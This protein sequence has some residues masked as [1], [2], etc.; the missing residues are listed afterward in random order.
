[1][2]EAE[3]ILN[4]DDDEAGRYAK[5]R[6][7]ERAGLRVAEAATGE[8][9]LRHVAE[10]A[11]D[12][13]LLDVRLPDISGIEVCR[14]I[15][16]E[17]PGTLVLQISVAMISG[18]DRVR[19]LEGGADSYLTQPVAPEELV[20]VIRALL[21]MRAAERALRQLNATL[22]ARVAERTRDLATANASL[23]AEITERKRAEATA[24]ALYR[25]TPLPLH[26]LDPAGRLLTVSDRWLEFFGY[27]SRQ[28]VI[29][30][31]ITEFMPP[32]SATRFHEVVWPLIL[33]GR[34]LDDMELQLC[35]SDGT[36]RDVLV[37]VRTEHDASGRF[38]R[39]LAAL[40]DITARKR[41]E[42]GLRQAQKMEVFGQLAGGIAHDMNNVLQTVVSGTRMVGVQAEKPEMVRRLAGLIS[43]AA[44]R[45]AAIARRLLTFARRGE[46][47][48]TRVD[49]AALVEDVREV[50]SYTLGGRTEVVL[51]RAPASGE[52]AVL[53][54]KQQL[55][56]VLL[57]L[58]VNARDAMPGGGTVTLSVLSCPGAGA[59]G[60]G[61][62][63]LA[64]RDHGMGMD[65]ETRARATEPFFTTKPRGQGTGLGL[66]MAQ[67]FAEQSGGELRIETAPGAGTTVTLLLPVSTA[68][69]ETAAA[70]APPAPPTPPARLLVVDDDPLVR[71]VLGAVFEGM[72]HT[73]EVLESG[74]AA[75]ARLVAGAPCDLLLTDLSM[76]GL[77]GLAL[78]REARRQRPGLPC[79]LLTGNLDDDAAAA[80]PSLSDGGPFT[81]L[82]KPMAP[83]ALGA[84][85]GQLLMTGEAQDIGG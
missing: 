69:A 42:E 24:E 25:R 61:Q 76:P 75:L 73:A 31:H 40:V 67:G 23:T 15:K 77:S 12:L 64:V 26:C 66:A 80:L 74:D 84:A 4:V 52:I 46:L 28:S 85:V 44:E 36:L 39:S 30:R 32:D 2:S 47:R 65:A 41:A 17:H 51:E 81:V 79:I 20:A 57:N 56:T 45:G 9:A 3:L 62:V 21:R 68:P 11:P 29:G 72:G 33:S 16:Q 54:D 43:D 6:I 58:A 8:A 14:R 53:A 13:V 5:T 78:L 49:V 55:E 7:L 63:A 71:S 10:Q 37:S 38:L 60:Q 22:E 34:G 27:T 35:R 48:V 50:L 83:E 59:G 19:G 18:A 1:M 70:G 82:R